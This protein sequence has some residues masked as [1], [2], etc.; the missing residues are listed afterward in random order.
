MCEYQLGKLFTKIGK[1]FR[2]RLQNIF[3]EVKRA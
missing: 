1:N 3:V 2:K